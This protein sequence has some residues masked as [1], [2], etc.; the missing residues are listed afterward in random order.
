MIGIGAGIKAGVEL[1]EYIKKENPKTKLITDVHE[2][3]QI[4]A[5]LCHQT[6]LIV[7]YARHFNKIKKGCR[8]NE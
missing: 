3:I 6:D 8:E 4:P 2:C 5:F 7:E 1:F